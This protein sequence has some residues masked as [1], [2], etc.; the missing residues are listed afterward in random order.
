MGCYNEPERKVL[1]LDFAAIGDLYQYINNQP[2]GLLTLKQAKSFLAQIT[3]ALAYL[4]SILVAHRDVKPEN[5]LVTGPDTV[6]LTD[7]GLSFRWT[8]KGNS[9]IRR[10]LCGTPEYI[11]PEVAILPFQRDSYD[12]RF[13]D[14]WSLGILAH[15]LFDGVTPFYMCRSKKRRI[16][17]EGGFEHLYEVTLWEVSTF[18][19][20]CGFEG[21]LE[22]EC[23]G[24]TDFVGALLKYKPSKRMSAREG[25]EHVFLRQSP[26]EAQAG[27]KRSSIDQQP[28]SG[29]RMR[30]D[31]AIP[32][33]AADV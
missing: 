21:N 1:V 19:K 14:R 7:F 6:K 26:A 16:A 28:S 29:K 13:V 9:R 20:F 27:D 11:P 18:R 17:N 2:D 31:D 22:Q 8:S 3:S 24:L 15:E 32:H 4:E 30:P 23:H 5:I 25:S 12:A 10:T 33:I